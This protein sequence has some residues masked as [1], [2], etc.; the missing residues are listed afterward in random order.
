[1]GG[2]MWFQQELD[3][4]RSHLHGA[5]DDALG[6]QEDA[7]MML[8]KIESGTLLFRQTLRAQ[9]LSLD[10]SPCPAEAA[11]VAQSHD[12]TNAQFL[13]GHFTRELLGGYV[14][15]ESG[16]PVRVNERQ[17]GA[18]GLEDGD[19]VAA[20]PEGTY[21]SGNPRYYF[22][23]LRPGQGSGRVR[24]EI[25][26][27]VAADANGRP[28]VE[29]GRL[30]VRLKD[31]ELER[32]GAECGCVVTVAFWKD[33]AGEVVWGRI[34]RTHAVDPISRGGACASHEPGPI[35]QSHEPDNHKASAV[36]PARFVGEPTIV[37]VGGWHTAG[38][39]EGHRDIGARPYFLD[40]KPHRDW[41]A[42]IRSKDIVIILTSYCN[43]TVSE[44]VR[45]VTEKQGTKLYFTEAKNWASMRRF[46]ES[47]VIPQW[48]NR[49][50]TEVAV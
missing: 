24:A 18:V 37:Y 49:S 8:Q 15:L 10:R 28:T 38:F 27:T 32:T 23:R 46:L 13:M 14:H 44:F 21:P 20:R 1:M 39:R 25:T 7:A 45:E 30:V 48:N 9:F 11:P 41:I 47:D 35:T 5:L 42:R 36:V 22:S 33:E 34:V 26:G 40:G 4:L 43:H 50:S 3:W 2:N 29:S 12:T 6:S 19:L 31:R 17:V 16:E